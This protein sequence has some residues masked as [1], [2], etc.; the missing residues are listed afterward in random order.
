MEAT[1]VGTVRLG[2]ALAMMYHEAGSDVELQEWY[3]RQK[4]FWTGVQACKKLLWDTKPEP[5]EGLYRTGDLRLVCKELL[6]T[7]VSL[8]R[9]QLAVALAEMGFLV[10]YRDAE[11]FNTNFPC[12]RTVEHFRNEGMV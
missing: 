6:G 8:S 10:L 4:D 1:N 11:K 2:R 12:K 5:L 9:A 7:K 3:A